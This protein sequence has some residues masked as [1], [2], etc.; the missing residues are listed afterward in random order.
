MEKF[1]ELES[2][3]LKVISWGDDFECVPT[4]CFENIMDSFK[5]TKSQLKGVLSSLFKKGAILEGKFPNGLTAYHLNC[6]LD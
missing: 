5:G 1:T 4:E 2:E 3:V 6:D